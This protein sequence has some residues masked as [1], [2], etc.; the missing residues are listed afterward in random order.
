MRPRR[1]RKGGDDRG[2]HTAA[3]SVA[4]GAA[5]GRV[6]ITGRCVRASQQATRARGRTGSCLARACRARAVS[7]IVSIDLQGC[8]ALSVSCSNSVPCEMGSTLNLVL[9]SSRACFKS[10]IAPHATW[11]YDTYYMV[12]RWSHTSYVIRVTRTPRRTRDTCVTSL[13]EACVCVG[14]VCSPLLPPRTHDSRV[15]TAPVKRG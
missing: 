7:C 1:G 15:T 14:Y 12:S 11:I 5:T 6:H 13:V 4:V 9:T 2:L 10:Q 3:I 8:T